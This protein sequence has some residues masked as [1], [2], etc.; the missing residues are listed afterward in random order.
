M[1]VIIVKD[2]E[3]ASQKACEIM[4]DVVKNNPTANLG[5]A[6]G[7]T[8]IRLYELMREEIIRKME[9]LIKQLSHLILMN[10]LVW[11]NLILKVIIILCVITYLMN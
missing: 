11:I 3:E 4:L 6:T 8:P 2:Y 7:S 5:L 1:K 10:I 9:L